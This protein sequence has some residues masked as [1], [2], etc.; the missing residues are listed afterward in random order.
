L[1]CPE[2]NTALV[3]AGQ[4]LKIVA[5][6]SL[7]E[8]QQQIKE[9]SEA[10]AQLGAKENDLNYKLD[11]LEEKKELDRLLTGLEKA[12]IEH[13]AKGEEITEK[14]NKLGAT[15]K[16]AIEAEPFWK[17]V[18]ELQKELA[19]IKSNN[20]RLQELENNAKLIQKLETEFFEHDFHR[21]TGVRDLLYQH[22]IKDCSKF[23]NEV[24][25]ML[26]E[27]GLGEIEFAPEFD[28]EGNVEKIRLR[29]FDKGEW[30]PYDEREGSMRR[31]LD[32]FAWLANIR[33]NPKKVDCLK[34]LLLDDFGSIFDER[35]QRF[36]NFLC[37]QD[38]VVL[39]AWANREAER[40]CHPAQTIILGE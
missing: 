30:R 2:C 17:R 4:T 21:T 26:G 10:K 5:M 13:Q 1:Y 25:K 7:A 3:L 37:K 34:L 31:I 19:V 24:N 8:L 18:D 23:S 33:L 11:L 27:C 16:D 15:L 38:L 29:H 39:F 35:L 9:K 28:R 36:L 14:I 32:L 6:E 40:L 22:F 12:H 20:K